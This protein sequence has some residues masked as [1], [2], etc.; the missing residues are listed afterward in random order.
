MFGHEYCHVVVRGQFYA[1][2]K[3]TH[4]GVAKVA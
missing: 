3:R 2:S 4:V 1:E